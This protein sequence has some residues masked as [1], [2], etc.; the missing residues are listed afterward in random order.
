MS[1]VDA[2][3]R[4]RLVEAEA[5]PG[6]GDLSPSSPRAADEQADAADELTTKLFIALRLVALLANC[7]AGN[8][9]AA[10]LWCFVRPC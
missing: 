2:A 1:S 9:I 6:D 7:V 5:R 8:L 10:A 3:E 4:E